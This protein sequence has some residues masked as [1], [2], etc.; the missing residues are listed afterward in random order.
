MLGLSYGGFYTLFLTAA[1]PRI[2][3]AASSCFFND[4]LEYAWL[5][6]TWFDSAN[7]IL[8]GEICQLICPRPLYVEVALSDQIFNP[9]GARRTAVQVREAYTRLGVEERFVFSTFEGEHELSKDEAIIDFI[10]QYL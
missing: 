4:R 2:K 8:D 6:W 10:C 3:V 9:E 7:K 1:D 5:D